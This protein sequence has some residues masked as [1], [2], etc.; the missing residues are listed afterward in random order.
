MMT[1]VRMP[2][3][4]VSETALFPERR[5]R[6]RRCPGAPRL[7]SGTAVGPFV[8]R[9]VRATHIRESERLP[10]WPRRFPTGG[11]PRVPQSR[12]ILVE[13]PRPGLPQPAGGT[14]LEMG[15]QLFH[16]DARGQFLTVEAGGDGRSDPRA[17][18][19]AILPDMSGDR[20]GEVGHA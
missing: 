18:H 16:G 8:R 9:P 12:D 10:W 11:G 13:P 2:R 15:C 1:P 4:S 17:E 20:H 19:A 7:R 3:A 14:P 5:P 6:P